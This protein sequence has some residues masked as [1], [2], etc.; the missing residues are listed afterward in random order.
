MN[1]EAHAT[2]VKSIETKQKS[3]QR[4]A[5]DARTIINSSPTKSLSRIFAEDGAGD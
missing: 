2:L 5:E 4:S 3:L 1:E